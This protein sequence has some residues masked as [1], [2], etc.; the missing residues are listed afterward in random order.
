MHDADSRLAWRP[1]RTWAWRAWPEPSRLPHAT[2]DYFA[3]FAAHARD[4]GAKIIGG[5]CGATPTEIRRSPRP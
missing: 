1:C 3:D 2:P 4:L 5:C